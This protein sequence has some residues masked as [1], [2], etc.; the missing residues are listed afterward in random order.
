MQNLIF[1]TRRPIVFTGNAQPNH[2]GRHNEVQPCALKSRESTVSG[3]TGLIG[4]SAVRSSGLS[5][6]RSSESRERYLQL[7]DSETSFSGPE[8]MFSEFSSFPSFNFWN[9]IG[10]K[11]SLKNNCIR[12]SLIEY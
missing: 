5:K 3:T 9:A 10:W 8:T 11:C 6:L 12:S 7:F 4:P 2:R 1:G